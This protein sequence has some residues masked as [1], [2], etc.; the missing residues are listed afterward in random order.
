VLD[1]LGVTRL[2][3]GDVTSLRSLTS[4]ERSRIVDACAARD[5]A[6]ETVNAV[7]AQL[8]LACDEQ[9]AAAVLV[10]TLVRSL[11]IDRASPSEIAEAAGMTRARVYQIRDGRR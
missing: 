3:L 9:S 11:M 1:V 7:E 4:D 6:R 2:T 5:E 8:V 10:T